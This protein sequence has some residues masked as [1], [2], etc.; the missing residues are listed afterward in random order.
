M[1][2]S[3][4]LILLPQGALA[5]TTTSRVLNSDER[6]SSLEEEKTFHNSPGYGGGLGGGDGGGFGRSSCG[7]LGGGAGG[8]YGVLDFYKR[9][10][11]NF[12]LKNLS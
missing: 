12:F 9:S 11:N 7:G 10:G 3:K 2:S 1:M 8:G 4:L 6:N 5:C